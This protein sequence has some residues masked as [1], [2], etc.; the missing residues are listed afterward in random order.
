MKEQLTI[1]RASKAR[2]RLNVAGNVSRFRINMNANENETMTNAR[3][4][5]ESAKRF[6]SSLGNGLSVRRLIFV[7]EQSPGSRRAGSPEEKN[8]VPPA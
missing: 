4:E 5:P 2:G 1:T 3:M 6:T 8:T 7:P